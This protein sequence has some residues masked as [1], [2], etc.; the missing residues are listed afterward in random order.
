MLRVVAA[1][2]AAPTAS[3]RACGPTRRAGDQ[4]ADSLG[5]TGSWTGAWIGHHRSEGERERG[6]RHGCRGVAGIPAD[7][8]DTAGHWALV[9]MSHDALGPAD[10]TAIGGAQQEVFQSQR[11]PPARTSAVIRRPRSPISQESLLR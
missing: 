8:D 9:T 10:Q 4:W 2:E 3:T 7:S 6:S 5:L 1:C 11:S